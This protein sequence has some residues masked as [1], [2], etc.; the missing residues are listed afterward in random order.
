M[1]ARGI[2]ATSGRQWRSCDAGSNLR[3]E[4]TWL[5]TQASATPFDSSV[6]SVY[7]SF[8]CE[9]LHATVALRELEAM[10]SFFAAR[11]KGCATFAATRMLLLPGAFGILAGLVI[12]SGFRMTGLWVLGCV[13]GVDLI[14]H[15][16]ALLTSAWPPAAR[17]A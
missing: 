7:L 10:A 16:I 9:C 12:L 8:H 11:W 5:L 13:L 17:T 15:G 4:I 3:T 2:T 14:S 6:V 1:A